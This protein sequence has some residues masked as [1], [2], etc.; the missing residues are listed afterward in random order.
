MGH[1]PRHRK[2]W[3]EFPSRELGKIETL[4][5][6]GDPLRPDAKA[7]IRGQGFGLTRSGFQDNF[8]ARSQPHSADPEQTLES[9]DSC[10]FPWW[11]W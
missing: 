10:M 2:L 11:W 1:S 4:T 5:K 8:A 3:K 6:Q 7:L 9:T